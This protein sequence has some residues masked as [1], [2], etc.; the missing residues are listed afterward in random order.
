MFNNFFK[1]EKPFTGMSGF[2]GGFVRFK[3]GGS[4]SATGGTKFELSGYTYHLFTSSGSLVVEGGSAD[5]EYYR[6]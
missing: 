1:K 6:S 4:F 3:S 2:G 5:T